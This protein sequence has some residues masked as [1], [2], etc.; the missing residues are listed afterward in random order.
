[1][2]HQRY[3][4]DFWT[5]EDDLGIART[6]DHM[7]KLALDVPTPF[8]IGVIGKWGGAVKQMIAA[9]LTRRLQHT[10]DLLW[11]RDE[12]KLPIPTL[13][14][15]ELD[16]LLP[17]QGPLWEAVVTRLPIKVIRV[18]VCM[19]FKLEM[20]LICHSSVRSEFWSS[21]DFSRWSK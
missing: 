1:L 8:T 6:G 19:I 2:T 14:S 21:Q 5:L 7:A 3:N 15:F 10:S 13:T 12:N 16:I 17:Q 9:W 4:N 18:A 20:R 11:S